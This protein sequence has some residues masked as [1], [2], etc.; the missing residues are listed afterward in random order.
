M[1][2][3]LEIW[4]VDDDESIRW[5]M[6]KSLMRA[7]M[8]VQTFEGAAEL[9]DAL[10]EDTPDV[11]ITDI[12]MP[13]VSGL[14][15]M[16]RVRHEKPGL[17]VIVMTAHS[18]LDAAVASYKGG[19]FEYLPKPFDVDAVAELVRRAAARRVEP[20]PLP[21]LGSTAII[22]EA[23]AMQDVFRAIGRLSQSQITVMITGESGTG[24]ELVARALHVNS[25]RVSKP[26]IAV[27]TA[28]IPKD[29]M[30]SEFFGHERGAFTGAQTQ[31]K[32]RFEQTD[33]GT[34][35]LDEIGDMPA[36][37]Q[38][39]LLRVL[40][41][42]EFY[43]VGGVAPVK[44]D[45]RV[46]AATHQD[47][48]TLVKEGRF[49]ED[50]YHRLNV[51]RVRIPS[52]AERAEDIPLLMRHF[53]VSAAKE[54]QSETKRV[55]PEVM[56][57]LQAFAWP[58][59]VRQLENVCRWLT[60]MA[61]GQD[62]HLNDLPPELREVAPRAVHAAA[63]V[64]SAPIADAAP[65]PTTAPIVRPS[66]LSAAE[67]FAPVSSSMPSVPS[68]AATRDESWFQTLRAWADGEFAAGRSALLD[69]AMPVF[70][71]TLIQSALNAT[72]GQRQEAARRLGWGRNTLTRKIQE[73]GMDDL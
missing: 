15:L 27:N 39:R 43:R 55:T 23:P 67:A 41:N 26:F 44:V 60:V 29:L 56:E 73:L 31:R 48:E 35:F 34:L 40:Q 30:E 14:E 59:N 63:A 54:L 51:I 71:R 70:E 16:E 36:D 53:L 33:G 42:G 9:F 18:D 52:L 37:L 5:V 47:L 45:V 38:T 49:R 21:E 69:E 24:K 13:G 66:V 61:P 28:A 25:P 20:E 62:V 72:K 4:V 6:Q 64:E 50:L 2:K 8:K 57:R 7:G 58:G 17:P 19:A 65:T 46:I 68:Q 32:G 22:G 10:S 11:L 12:R 1:S 3:A